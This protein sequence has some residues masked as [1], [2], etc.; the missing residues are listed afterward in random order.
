MESFCALSIA[1]SIGITVVDTGA[2]AIISDDMADD[3]YCLW[4]SILF[5]ASSACSSVRSLEDSRRSSFMWF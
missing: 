1:A 3:S 5:F 2:G 4:Y